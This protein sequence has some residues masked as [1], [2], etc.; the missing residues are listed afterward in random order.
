MKFS[1]TVSKAKLLALASLTALSLQIPL[2]N[3]AGDSAMLGGGQTNIE[4]TA[5]REGKGNQGSSGSGSA[6][7]S[8]GNAGNTRQRRDDD[9]PCTPI[10]G[11][12]KCIAY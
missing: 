4:R 10:V 5:P 7:P 6:S 9:I 3:A 2:V 1:S 8:A 11:T 12:T